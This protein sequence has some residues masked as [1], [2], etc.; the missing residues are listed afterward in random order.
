MKTLEFKPD[1]ADS[2]PLYLQLAQL[3][4]QAIRD[5]RYQ[6]DEA[7][8]SERTLS[9]SLNVSRVTARKAIDQLVEQGLIVRRRGS[10]NYIAPR[11]EQPLSRLTSFS[12]ELHQRG[13]TPSSRW[14]ERGITASVPEEQLSLGLSPGTRVARLE[15]LR[16]ADDVV[17]AYEVS[18]IPQSALPDPEAVEGSLYEYLARSGHAPVRALQHIRALNA[19]AKLADL[20]EVPTGQAVLFITRIGYLESGQAVE[21]THSY[22]RSDYYDFVAEMRREG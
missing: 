14:L 18:V 15:R 16:L 12:E 13:Y 10:G 11:L 1:P 17:M 19:H 22:C 7:L 5:G 3:L 2:S 8:P 4:S 21:L 6:V 20:L 9:E